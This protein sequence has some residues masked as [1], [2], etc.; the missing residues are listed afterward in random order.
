MIV[1]R[2]RLGTTGSAVAVLAAALVIAGCASANKN[3]PG[4]SSSSM[5][6]MSGMS[7]TGSSTTG[8][9]VSSAMKMAMS[10]TVNPTTA[11]GM[12]TKGV[13]LGGIHPIPTQLLAST[14]WQGMR[15]E[16]F[17]T[18][19]VPFLVYTGTSFHEVKPTNKT[20]FHLM[21]SLTDS[22]TGVA[23]PYSTVWATIKRAGKVVYD[24]RQYPMISRY[25]GPHY[26]NDVQVP[27]SGSYQLTLLVSPPVSARHIEYQNVW[28]TPHRAN[29]TFQWKQ[30]TST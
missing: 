28:L 7:T 5:A 18:T 1:R 14:V 24:E 21:V 25:M 2:T 30:P 11:A 27:G 20:S 16:A 10:S 6:N 29:F 9:K 17:A 23:I 4:T 12:S 13:S 22:E 19:A 26:G 15:I 8:S 3:D